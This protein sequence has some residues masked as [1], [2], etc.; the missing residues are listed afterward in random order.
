MTIEALSDLLKFSGLNVHIVGVEQK[1]GSTVEFTVAGDGLPKKCEQ[2]GK[3][4]VLA[5]NTDVLELNGNEIVRSDNI[6]LSKG[7]VII[8]RKNVDLCCLPD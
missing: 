8:P 3:R 5:Y 1:D 7:Y 2:D 6:D 4:L